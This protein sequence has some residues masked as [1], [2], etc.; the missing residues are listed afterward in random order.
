MFV[1]SIGRLANILKQADSKRV[2]VPTFGSTKKRR[3]V[4]AATSSAEI[5]LSRQLSAKEVQQLEEDAWTQVNSK[6]RFQLKPAFLTWKEFANELRRYEIKFKPIRRD[7][8]LQLLTIKDFGVLEGSSTGELL[9]TDQFLQSEVSPLHWLLETLEGAL[10]G[11]PTSQI[12]KSVS[13]HFMD[14]TGHR[15]P[16]GIRVYRDPNVVSGIKVLSTACRFEFWR[17]DDLDGTQ[18][19][20]LQVSAQTATYLTMT[21]MLNL[22]TDSTIGLPA[23]NFTD[24]QTLK[25]FEA[26]WYR[27]RELAA[28]HRENW[29]VAP[30]LLQK[31]R[32]S[33]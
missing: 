27:L 15:Y 30:L 19:P 33:G 17:E 7:Q 12:D 31:Q 18:V 11:P 14:P 24:V 9:F 13:Y 4:Q 23:Y 20:L 5:D 8:P 28:M 29:P 32:Q 16:V 10:G 2:E 22:L 25:G 1:R 26:S 6:Y 3:A 21:S